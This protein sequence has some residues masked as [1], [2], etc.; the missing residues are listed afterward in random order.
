MV[1]TR[2][3]DIVA[4]EQLQWQR[5]RQRE[6]GGKHQSNLTTNSLREFIAGRSRKGLRGCSRKLKAGRT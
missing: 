3:S 5:T 1:S 6:E 2:H 4:E